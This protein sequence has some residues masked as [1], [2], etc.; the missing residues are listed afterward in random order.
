MINN[1]INPIKTLKANES[2]IQNATPDNMYIKKCAEVF[3]KNTPEHELKK[4]KHMSAK[5]CFCGE[6]IAFAYGVDAE[7]FVSCIKSML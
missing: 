6:N 4:L 3:I 5:G 2:T 7:S 1:L